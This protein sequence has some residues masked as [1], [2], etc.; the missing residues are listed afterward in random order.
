[1]LL[2]DDPTAAPPYDITLDRVYVHGDRAR[3][4]KRGVLMNGKRLSVLTSYISDIKAADIDSQ[5]ILGYNGAGPLTIANNYLELEAS[6]E[7]IM[8][9]GADPAVVNLGPSDILIRRNHLFKPLTWPSAI[10]TCLTSTVE[11]V[12]ASRGFLNRN[13]VALG[14]D[15]Q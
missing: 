2:G 10:Q 4:Q 13:R 9:G 11:L 7:N 8:F 1:V 14:L 15:L 3:G 12:S 6:E 5:A